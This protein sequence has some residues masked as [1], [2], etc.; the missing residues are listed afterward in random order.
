MD[1]KAI[2]CNFGIE[3][4]L[5]PTDGTNQ[6]YS[7]G[8]TTYPWDIKLYRGQ[9]LSITE[10]SFTGGIRRTYPPCTKHIFL[11]YGVYFLPPN[12]LKFGNV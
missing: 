9:D 1:F 12:T 11:K 7:G 10:T 2:L 8:Y 4:V 3:V 5:R 6:F